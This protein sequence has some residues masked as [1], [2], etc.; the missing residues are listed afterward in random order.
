METKDAMIAAICL[1]NGATLATRNTKDFEGLDLKLVNPFE[2]GLILELDEIQCLFASS[3]WERRSF[4]FRRCS[5]AASMPATRSLRSI[6]SRRGRAGGAGSI[7]RN[8]RCI[9]R[10]N[11]SALPVC[12]PVN[13]KDPE[14]R[15][16][17]RALERRCRRRRCL[18]PAAAG[19]DFERHAARLLQ[20]PC[21]AA[22][23][24]ARCGTDPAGDHGRRR[25]DR[26]DGDEDGQGAGYRR[27]GADQRGR[28]RREHDGWR[29]ARPAD[30]GR[31][32]AMAR[33][34]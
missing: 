19:G 34:W 32:Q 15:E 8:R 17:F 11:C 31:C 2:D 10:P 7:C 3:S 16:R 14:E 29:T 30:A 12:T 33:P 4:R 1:R 22:A 24:L 25:R 26:H 21:L 18:R 6:R 27:R 5:A 9:R 20:R 23:A 13:F 28:D